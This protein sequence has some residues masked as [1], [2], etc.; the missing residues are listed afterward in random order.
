MGSADAL[1]WGYSC[2]SI[3]DAR[4]PALRTVL[5]E[6]DADLRAEIGEYLVRRGHDMTA[7]G[8]LAEARAVLVRM[9]SAEPPEAIICDVN[10]PDGSGVDLCLEAAPWMPQCRWVLMSGAHEPEQLEDKLGRIPGPPRWTIVDKP[11]SM[12]SLNQALSA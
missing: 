9:Q 4:G 8:T 3:Q 11:V 12:R 6:D 1:P 5:V 2:V 7:C 10:L